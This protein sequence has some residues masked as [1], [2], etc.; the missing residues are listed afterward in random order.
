MVAHVMKRH[1]PCSAFPMG[2]FTCNQDERRPAW[3]RIGLHTFLLFR[4]HETGL[5]MN[6]DLSD[7][8][9]IAGQRREISTLYAVGSAIYLLDKRYHFVP[10]PGTKHFAPV[11]CKRLQE[12]H[13]RTSSYWADFAPVPCKYLRIF[14]ESLESHTREQVPLHSAIFRAT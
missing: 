11:S 1:W 8:V 2:V 7:F 4:L 10:K 14:P 9:S 6:S 13:T 12:F 3:V 5:K